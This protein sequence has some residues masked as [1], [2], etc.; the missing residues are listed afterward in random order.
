[1]IMG[2]RLAPFPSIRTENTL[3]ESFGVLS[4]TDLYKCYSEVHALQVVVTSLLMFLQW[5]PL[6]VTAPAVC[7]LMRFSNCKFKQKQNL[8]NHTVQ[9]S[10][11]CFHYNI[12]SHN[13]TC[14]LNW[15]KWMN[16]CRFE[17]MKNEIIQATEAF[18]RVRAQVSGEGVSAAASVV[19]QVTFE[20]FLARVQFDVSEQVTLLSEGSTALVALERPFP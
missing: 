3:R 6:L 20:R 2:Y 11:C 16:Q 15:L 12:A 4:F 10:L 17:L 9:L 1:M 18:T 7:T 13:N 14:F 8:L 19:A 5:A